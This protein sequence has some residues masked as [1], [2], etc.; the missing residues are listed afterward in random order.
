MNTGVGR[1]NGKRKNT[2]FSTDSGKIG[3]ISPEKAERIKTHLCHDCWLYPKNR[4][5]EYS[6]TDG[7]WDL[8]VCYYLCWKLVKKNIR[9]KK[10]INNG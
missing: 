10:L 4:D 5:F 3:A 9:L 2:G 8:N 1:G 6:L 7:I